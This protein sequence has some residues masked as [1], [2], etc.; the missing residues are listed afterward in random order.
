MPGKNEL[1]EVFGEEFTG[2]FD[3][4]T[5]Y[6]PRAAQTLTSGSAFRDADKPV[7]EKLFGP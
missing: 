5:G 6:V 1:R 3:M 7:L 4:N 2:H